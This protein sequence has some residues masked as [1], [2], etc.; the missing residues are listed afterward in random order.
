MGNI[1]GTL[2]AALWGAPLLL[3]LFGTH[4]FLTVRLSGIQRYTAKAIRF[5][6]TK[7]KGATGE[8][9]P[10]SA[11]TTALAA[12]LGTGNIVGVATAVAAGG[13]GAVFWMWISGVLGMSTKYTE[14]LLSV[15]YRVKTKNGYC[16]GPMYVMEKALH[17][18]PLGC[19]FALFTAL[20]ALGVGASVQS[21]S[22][23][24]LFKDTFHISP[25][26]SG[27]V[28]AFLAGSVLLGGIKSISKVCTLIIPIAGALYIFSNLFILFIGWKTIPASIALIFH[29]AFSGHAAVGGFTGAAMKEAIRFGISR[30]LFSNEAGLGSS[31]IVDAAAQC[32]TPVRQAL[33]ASTGVF[34]DTVVLAALT[35]LMLVNSGLWCKGLNGG[36]LTSAVFASIPICGPAMLAI[37]LFTFAF[38]TCIG[39]SYYAEKAVEYLWGTRAIRPY[40]YLYVLAIFL[41]GILSVKSVWDF[42]DI[43]NALMT[44][45]NL[46]T[47]LVLN[48]VAV[49]ET[50]KERRHGILARK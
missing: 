47:I 21:N 13:P 2:S 34:W 15:K 22:I 33:I 1:L 44:I 36:A 37:S 31:P 9:S 19:V 8:I 35:G 38:A 24:A 29:D 50:L 25:I 12:T 49:R 46:A 5:S 3:A 40:Q 4:L 6:V 11:L 42:S 10:F 45:P 28:V 7:E 27:L 43:A 18:R 30:G 48:G 23:S 32:R 14:S 17:A 16:G 39:W 26:I 20:A 41:G